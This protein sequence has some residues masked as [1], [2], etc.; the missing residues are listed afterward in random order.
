MARLGG[1]SFDF[2]DHHTAYAQIGE[3]FAYLVKL[4]EFNHCHGQF[5]IRSFRLVNL[6][7]LTGHNRLAASAECEAFKAQITHTYLIYAENLIV[8]LLAPNY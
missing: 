6:L 2:S 1:K 8:W 7:L 4:E 3:R 5:H